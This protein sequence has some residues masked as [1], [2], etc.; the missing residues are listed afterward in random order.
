MSCSVPKFKRN[1]EYELEKL[2]FKKSV[3]SF[4]F[5]PCFTLVFLLGF[6][7]FLGLFLRLLLVNNSNPK[8]FFVFHAVAVE[9]GADLNQVVHLSLLA[10]SEGDSDGPIAR[11]GFPNIQEV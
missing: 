3:I 7:F 9:F 10:R 2:S 1:S 8:A 11:A 6:L 5:S 4:S